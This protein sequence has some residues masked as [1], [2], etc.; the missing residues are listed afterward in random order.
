M[1]HI[2][3]HDPSP[4]PYPKSPES[5]RQ[6]RRQQ[7]KSGK[8]KGRQMREPSL[9]PSRPRTPEPQ[10]STSHATPPSSDGS[11]PRGRTRHPN[12]SPPSPIILRPTSLPPSQPTMASPSSSHH[13]ASQRGSP[14]AGS[15]PATAPA[16]AAPGPSYP[17]WA[18]FLTAPNPA[19]GSSM[20]LAAGLAAPQDY[21]APTAVPTM[22]VV[23]RMIWDTQQSI[24]VLSIAMGELTRQ[25]NDL[26][27]V[28]TQ[29]SAPAPMEH[30]AKA[31]LS[32]LKCT[33]LCLVY[34]FLVLRHRL[35]V[36]SVAEQCPARPSVVWTYC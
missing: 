4:A 12:P 35:S 13:T 20:A 29:A 31:T 25:V 1:A 28:Q 7:K 16:T 8:G 11:T 24:G 34:C 21:P 5:R 22:E 26:V 3:S 17:A 36:I 9:A 27:Q 10:P 15:A 33:L 2:G 30:G 14:Q 6:V 32:P 19:M 23:I 18:Q